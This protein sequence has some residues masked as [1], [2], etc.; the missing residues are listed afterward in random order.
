MIDF[1]I[2][3]LLDEQ[4]SFAWLERQL[5]PEGLRCP[6]WGSAARRVTRRRGAFPAYRCVKC[7]RYHTILSGTVFAKTRQPPS[8]RVLILRG[9]AKG[10]PTA[11]LARELDLSRKRCTRCDDVCKPTGTRASRRGF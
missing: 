7:D 11:R 5:H 6:R 3:E 9:I 8:K 10:E 1:P 2:D 4:A